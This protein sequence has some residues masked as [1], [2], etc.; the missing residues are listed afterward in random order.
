MKDETTKVAETEVATTV[1]TET[2]AAAPKVFISV[3]N[4]RFASDVKDEEERKNMRDEVQSNIDNADHTNPYSVRAVKGNKANKFTV[5]IFRPEDV[6]AKGEPKPTALPIAKAK[7]QD[8]KTEGETYDV[9]SMH[10][11]DFISFETLNNLVEDGCTIRIIGKT[12]D[13][14]LITEAIPSLEPKKTDKQQRKAEGKDLENEIVKNILPES[15]WKMRRASLIR[16]NIR[17]G[18]KEYNNFIKKILKS[19]SGY[20]APKPNIDYE[21]GKEGAMSLL[22]RATAAGNFTILEGPMGCG[23]NVAIETLAWLLNYKLYQ[24]NCSRDTTIT[25]M[26]G[27]QTT[28]P[29]PTMDKDTIKKVVASLLLNQGEREESFEEIVEFV[30]TALRSMSPELEMIYGV[31]AKAIME[32]NEGTGV[33]LDIDEMNLCDPN[34]LSGMFNVLSDGHSKTIY[35]TGIGEVPIPENLILV[36]T[37]NPC[38]G[39]YVGTQKQNVATISRF[40]TIKV[41]YPTSIIKV[42]TQYAETRGREIHPDYL[43]ALNKLYKQ[44]VGFIQTDQIPDTALNVR[45]LQRAVDMMDNGCDFIQALNYGFLYSL[46]EDEAEVIRVLAYDSDPADS[47]FLDDEDEDEEE[48]DIEKEDDEDDDE[49][50]EDEEEEE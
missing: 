14:K 16:Y 18:S 31:V 13:G 6:N 29:K 35:L 45:G 33:I 39:S 22:I 41:G 49:D 4:I 24:L 23:K 7:E 50:D 28:A 46:P 19:E 11:G 44:L 9:G 47:E 21:Q 26:V 27:Y 38:G 37:Q 8:Q 1:S 30:D 40:G 36:G 48:D 10:I 34:T 12:K 20:I 42:L 43:D 15:E 5:S 32:A 3:Q 25:D 2:G 17:P